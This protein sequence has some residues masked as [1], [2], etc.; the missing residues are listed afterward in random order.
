[1]GAWGTG[2]FQNDSAL[3]WADDL[4]QQGDLGLVEEALTLS[5]TQ[6]ESDT[7]PGYLVL[8]ALCPL[9]PRWLNH[10]CTWL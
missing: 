9:C 6:E 1:M 2:S 7:A 4:E 3:D 10:I 5:G 8:P